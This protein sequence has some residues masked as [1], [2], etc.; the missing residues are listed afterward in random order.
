MPARPAKV[1][2]CEP[3]RRAYSSISANTLPAAAPA[4]LGPAPNAAAAASAAAFLAAPASSTPTRSVVVATSNRA[5]ASASPT[6][7]AKAGSLV[8]STSEAPSSSAALAC[9]GPP[10]APTAHAFTRSLTKAA[11]RVPSGGTR[12][13]DMTS[14]PVRG[15]SE[16][17]CA[18]TVAGSAAAGTAKHTRSWRESSRSEARTGLTDLGSSTPGR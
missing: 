10:R 16:P 11:G 1:S 14:T 3:A 2:G 17:A 9:A 5:A 15:V 12:P 7:R 8:A 13:L 18:A 4:A 6:W